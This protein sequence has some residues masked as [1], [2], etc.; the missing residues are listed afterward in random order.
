MSN[1][2]TEDKVVATRR[3][4]TSYIGPLPPAAEFERYERAHPGA[5]AKMIEWV[6]KEAEHRRVSESRIID[7]ASK[8]SSRGQIFA[9]VIAILSLASIVVCAVL[10]QPVMVTAVPAIL[11]C[12]SLAAVF[13]GKKK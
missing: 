8:L 7:T 6:E 9:F 13:L 4:M 3:S 11:G 10:N 2:P 1:K 12:I 5:A